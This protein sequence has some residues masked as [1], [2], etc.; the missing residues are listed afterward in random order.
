MVGTRSQKNKEMA[1]N[2]QARSSHAIKD[3]VR[4]TTLEFVDKVLGRME[5]L[6]SSWNQ[7]VGSLSKERETIS[8]VKEELEELQTQHDELKT[9]FEYTDFLCTQLEG[10][11]KEVEESRDQGLAKI[12]NLKETLDKANKALEEAQ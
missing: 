11:V 7:E 6:E 5:T 4:D 12:V 2:S 9:Q 10:R 8:K 1:A 3:T